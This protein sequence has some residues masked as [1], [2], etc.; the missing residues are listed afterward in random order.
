[1][2]YLKQFEQ[3]PWSYRNEEGF[4]AEKALY[5]QLFPYMIH[6]NFHLDIPGTIL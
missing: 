1:M 2:L 3:T 4:A 6:K 5:S